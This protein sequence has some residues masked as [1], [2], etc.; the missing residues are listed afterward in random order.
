MVAIRCEPSVR[1]LSFPLLLKQ[2]LVCLRRCLTCGSALGLRN[3][4]VSQISK[5]RG[6]III[7]PMGK[8]NGK[9]LQVTPIQTCSS[10]NHKMTNSAS[11]LV[12]FA[13]PLHHA[14]SQSTNFSPARFF[15]SRLRQNYQ[16]SAVG[17]HSS[18][19]RTGSAWIQSFP[20][21]A[22]FLSAPRLFTIQLVPVPIKKER[23]ATLRDPPSVRKP[24]E[25]VAPLT[26]PEVLS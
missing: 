4:A 6:H 1:R 22:Y 11:Y 3:E 2:I 20:L 15:L 16:P 18:R 14:G 13:V 10:A 19:R 23:R 12:A 9:I 21:A 24:G 25:R 7:E 26:L 5:G 17:S 8:S